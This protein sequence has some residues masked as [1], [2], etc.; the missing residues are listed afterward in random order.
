MDVITGLFN[1]LVR[2]KQLQNKKVVGGTETPYV[3]AHGQ[4][5]QKFNTA[6]KAQKAELNLNAKLSPSKYDKVPETNITGVLNSD[7]NMTEINNFED[8]QKMPL[9]VADQLG[10]DLEANGPDQ[11]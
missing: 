11:R 9:R 7:M 10:H 2:G 8:T 3:T 1:R 5:T 6:F 4:K